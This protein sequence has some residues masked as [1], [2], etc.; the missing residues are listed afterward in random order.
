GEVEKV[1]NYLISQGHT[2]ELDGAIWLKTTQYEDEKDR[3][4]VKSDQTYTYLLPDIAYHANKLKRGFTHLI[5]VL[6]ADHHGYINRLKAAIAFVGGN[7]DQ[8]DIKILQMVRVLQNGEE[9]KMSKRSGK[10]ITLRDL[11]DEV[12]TD[13][14]R[15]MYVSKA[16]N[17]HMDLDLDLAVQNSNDNPVYYVQYAYARIASV[18]RVVEEKGF[19]FQAVNSFSHLHLESIE[20]LVLQLVQYPLIIEEAATK[21]LPHKLAQYLLDLAQALHTY[22]NDE[23]I[24]TDNWDEVREKLTVLK[25]VQIVLKD[26]LNLIG[27]NTKERM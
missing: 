25:A 12:G 17:T 27:V 15:F 18:F 11:M 16:L 8:V 9:I 5:D 20:Q 3:V 14:L 26:G 13:A 19:L 2:Y 24:I 21:R 6:G 10:A 23:R 22:Y 7:P 1:K 4:L